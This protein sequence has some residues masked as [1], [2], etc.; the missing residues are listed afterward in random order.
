MAIDLSTLM[1]QQREVVTTLDRPLFVSAGAGS[2]KTFTLTRRILW[3]LSPES[4]PYV[5]HLDGV[6]AITFT[7][8]AAAEIRERVRAALIDA[9]MDEEALSVDDAWIS[10]IHGMCARILRAHALE[11]GLDPEFSVLEETAAAELMDQAVDHVL[12]RVGLGGGVRGSGHGERPFAA[13]LGWYRLEGEPSPFGGARGASVREYVRRLLELSCALPGGMDDVRLW[14]GKVDF[15]GLRDMYRELSGGTA[16]QAA[17]AQTALEALDAFEAGPR[18]AR[19]LSTCMMACLAKMPRAGKAFPKERVALLKAEAADA[20]INAHIACGEPALDQLLE[21]AREVE[22]EYRRL[23]RECAA[24]DNNDLLRRTYEAFRDHEP[25]RAAFR[26]RF[27]LVMI[28]EFQ[29]TDQQQVDLIG[30]LAGEGG[31]ALCT[32]GDAQQSIYR[33]RGAEVEVFRRQQTAVAGADGG[34]GDDGGE[35]GEGGSAGPVSRDCAPAA[36]KLVKLVR[37]FRSHAEILQYVARVFDGRGGAGGL[38][39]D[40]LDL[41]PDSGRRDGL[42]VPGASR[43]QAVL[44]AGGSTEERAAAKA[45]AIAH[46]FRALADAGQPV[47]GMVLL[48][49]AMTRAE[50]YAAAFRAAGLDCVIAGGSVFAAAPEVGAVRSLVCALANPIDTAQGLASLLA[51][52][53]FALGVQE[54]LALATDADPRTGEVRRRNI[55]VGLMSDDDASGLGPLPLLDRARA[56]MRAALSRVGRDPLAAIARDVVD[57]SGWFARL[58][59]RGPEGQAVAANV[60]KALDAIGE[61]EAQLGNAP[62][63]IALAYDA[64]LA[65]KQAPGALN[66]EG[67]D[68]VRI[69]TV[70]ASKG[71]EFSVVAVADCFSTRPAEGCLQTRRGP[72][73]VEAVAVPDI[74]DRV[75]LPDGSSVTA[76]KV[77]TKF[78]DLSRR[79]GWLAPELIDDVS[80]SDSAAARFV[81]LR[82]E[83]SRL[84]EEERARLL[85]VA[86]TRARDV[87]ILAM[88]AR[89]GSEDKVPTAK[90]SEDGDL[91]G[92][93]LDRILPD[94][95]LD[96]DRLSFPNAQ[97]GDFELIALEEFAYGG[98]MHAASVPAGDEGAEAS[99]SAGAEQSA[100]AA[101]AGD[102]VT[103]SARQVEAAPEGAG[104][105]QAADSPGTPLDASAAEGDPDSPSSGPLDTFTLAYPAE[106]RFSMVPEPP[107]PRES[108]SYSSVAAAMHGAGED[109]AQE[110]AGLESIQAADALNA[111]A[112]PA[113]PIP[114]AP[115]ELPAIAPEIGELVDVVPDALE[116]DGEPPRA[117]CGGSAASGARASAATVEGD[118]LALGSAFHAAAQWMVEMGADAVPAARLDAFCRTWGCT[119][120]QRARLEGALARWASSDVRR[121]ALAWPLVRAEAPFF[122]PGS[123]VLSAFGAYAEGS[124]DLLCTDPADPSRALVID[125]KTGGAP[126]EPVDALQSRHALQARIYADALHAAGYARVTCRFVRVE[127]PDSEDP[128]QPQVVTF[129]L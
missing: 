43:R 11:L 4:G 105:A 79:G 121:E 123:R 76:E 46:R 126:D 87:L 15:S 38:M 48:L 100:P 95:G 53:M 39:S 66:E 103:A 51:S 27:R 37:N 89:V 63:R 16:A 118:P 57:A 10:T 14:R 31:R 8:D 21:L 29:D 40:F 111:A 35:G 20:F 73:G 64:F 97:P 124:I 109:R 34:E 90:L 127:Q 88:D 120:A 3:A 106:V 101:M 25:V 61:A 22:A 81:E 62:R 125:Y 83:T 6:L 54:F 99:S 65:G 59:R 82:E 9:G 114:G 67:G 28:D 122:A 85:Y 18:D 26:D 86:M 69:L 13:L 117:V 129:E 52:P 102:C 55:D 23:K 19:S 108:Y 32:V 5:E 47:G 42:A 77:R 104:D 96:S 24:M 58:E 68:A 107:E 12:S 50:T 74:F 45:A 33:F 110:G 60:L 7:K 113:E 75:T 78:R 30:Y 36:G 56:V 116:G 41:E 98:E 84:D 93:V 17:A 128:S 71:L 49:G 119:A 112:L 1:S 80:A 70:H 94:A 115:V 91:T 92:R 44:V 2:G 72:S